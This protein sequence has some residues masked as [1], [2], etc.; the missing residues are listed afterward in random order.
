MRI[1]LAILIL[2]LVLLSTGCVTSQPSAPPQTTAPVT[3]I[4]PTPT[5][6][7]T[8]TRPQAGVDPIIGAWDNGMVFNP[9]GSVGTDNTISWKANDM[10]QYSYF[11]T[12]EVRAVKDIKA[13]MSVDPTASSVEWI[14]NPYS[15][16][17]HIRDSLVPVHRVVAGQ[18][19]TAP[20]VNGT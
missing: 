19:T 2:V 17:L 20:A 12:T 3:T 16:T 5:P 13:G 1:P 15:D 7:P 6:V 8:V 4:I 18:G 11:V 9:G 14:Y 10:V